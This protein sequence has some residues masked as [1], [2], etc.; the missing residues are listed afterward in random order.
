MKIGLSSASFYPY[1]NTEDS[2][3]LMSSI[4]FNCG[5]IF[6]NTPS[7]YEEDFVKILVEEKNKYNFD[8]TSIHC[9]SSQYE[10]F[11]F[12]K[13]K[14]RRED[15]LKYFRQLCNA[16]KLLGADCYTFHGMRFANFRELDKKFVSEMY[17]ELSYIGSE[18]GI[19]VAQENVSWCM[20]SNLDFLNF[21]NESCKSPIYYTLDIKQAYKAQIEPERYIDVMGKNIVNFHVNDRDEK[22]ICLLPGK[23]KVDYKKI[24]SKLYSMEY[25][26][27][28]II[29]VYRDNYIKYGELRESGDF[30]NSIFYNNTCKL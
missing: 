6:L 1:V 8:V 5:E 29:E 19:K 10:P 20:S 16:A 28:A 4:G 23:G 12:D 30:L 3:K 2:I 24:L 11:I 22:N 21:L 7:E 13:Y 9:C 27:M 26:G 14:R 15:M 17:D 25:V 18:Y